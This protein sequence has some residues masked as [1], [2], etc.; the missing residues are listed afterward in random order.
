MIS[1]SVTND[2]EHARLRAPYLQPSVAK[3]ARALR[4]TWDASQGMWRF[5]TR[6]E[7]RV[8]DLAIDT[9][10]TDDTDSTPRV[11]VQ[12]STDGLS[13]RDHYDEIVLAGVSLARRRGRDEN[14]RLGDSVVVVTGEFSG[15][16]GSVKNPCLDFAGEHIVLEVR[17]VPEPMAEKMHTQAPD[18]VTI[19]GSGTIDR[20]ALLAR[21]EQLLTRV[22]EIDALLASSAAV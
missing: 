21:R 10:G 3:R 14:V 2:G 8:R 19:L 5:D 12:I 20:A 1:I 15:S 16:G 22:A 13:M 17:D 7:Q 11:T 6:D 18:A 9:F 4:G